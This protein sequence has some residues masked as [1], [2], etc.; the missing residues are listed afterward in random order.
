MTR[1]KRLRRVG[2]LC[3]HCLRNIAFYDAGWKDGEL[4][5]KE[6][7]WVNANGN[8]I[9]IAVLE[10][11]KLFAD[12]RGQHFWRKVVSAH[13]GFW[14]GMLGTLGLKQEGFEAYVKEM[15]TYR[16]RF[17]AHLDSDEKM[18]IPKMGLAKISAA[19]LYDYLLAN[20]DDGNFFHDAS[21]DAAGHYSKYFQLGKAAYEE[22]T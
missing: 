11:C 7:F 20:E 22:A 14:K 8:F 21:P 3:C 10:W 17:I 4:I 16:D 12:E 15:K 1:R 6:Q 13:D 5:R 9:D 19:Y 18:Q 2:I